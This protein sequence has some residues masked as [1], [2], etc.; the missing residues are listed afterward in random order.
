MVLAGYRIKWKLTA[1]NLP[2]HDVIVNLMNVLEKS[3][4]KFNLH[5]E[6]KP[7]NPSPSRNYS[8][9]HCHQKTGWKGI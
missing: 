2:H 6:L 3:E 8:N 5:N 7:S 1:Q 4:K 9:A